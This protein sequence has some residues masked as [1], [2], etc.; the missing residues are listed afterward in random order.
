MKGFWREYVLTWLLPP[1]LFALIIAL[2]LGIVRPSELRE[3]GFL[4]FTLLLFGVGVRD[5]RHWLIRRQ[6]EWQEKRDFSLLR[7]LRRK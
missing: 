1:A 3:N 5:L 2:G 6:I 7:W 4:L